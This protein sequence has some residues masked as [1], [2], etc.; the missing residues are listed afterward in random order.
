MGGDEAADYQRYMT[1]VADILERSDAVGAELAELLTDPGDTNRTEIQTRLDEFVATSEKLEVEAKALEAP[2]DLVEQ[3]VHQIFLLVMSFRHTGLTELKPSLMNA[4]EVQ[5]TE[6]SAEQ[7]SRALYY[8]INSD[9]LYGEVFMPEGHGDPQ[10]E[11]AHR[12]HRA[13][14]PSSSPTPISPPRRKSWRSS[15]SSRAPGNLQAV[16]GVALS[17]VVAMP[18]EKEITAGGTF[19]LTVQRRAGLR[20]DRREPGQ[21]GREERAGRRHPALAPIPPSRR[22]S[23]S[24]CP[25]SRPRRR[26]R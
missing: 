11:E 6:V 24:R 2:K 3:S 17:K 4:L 20:G 23:R 8:L 21:H 25:S 16:H 22:K 14:P 18:D 5:D 19:N 13:P 15:P 12:G 7:I 1:A 10:G 9:F 26:R